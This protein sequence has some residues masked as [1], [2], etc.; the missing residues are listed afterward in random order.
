MA[1]FCCNAAAAVANV[2]MADKHPRLRLVACRGLYVSVG[3][4]C[5]PTVCGGSKSIL[6]RVDCDFLAAN[7]NAGT[8]LQLSWME[9]DV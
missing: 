7:V 8:N 4:E 6:R 3:G 2:T 1:T 5:A 9:C